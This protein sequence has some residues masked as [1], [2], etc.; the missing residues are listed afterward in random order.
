MNLRSLL[1]VADMANLSKEDTGLPRN[2]FISGKVPL[3][4]PRL[5]VFVG[6]FNG[7]SI[8]MSIEDNPKQIA[9]K[10]GL[11]PREDL[12]KVALWII[13]NKELLLDYWYNYSVLET[14]KVLNN[15]KSI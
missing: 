1:K 12:E 2:I 7:A 10:A 13:K 3:H 8:S 4:K 6:P 14:K 5:K 15:L 11:L 9:G